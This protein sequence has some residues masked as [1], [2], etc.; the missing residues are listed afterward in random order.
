VLPAAAGALLEQ[1]EKLLD[2]GLHPLRIADG[3]EQA[4]KARA[5]AL[6][7]TNTTHQAL[8]SAIYDDEPVVGCL[9]CRIFCFA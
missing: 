8:P 5:P 4:C 1:A 2:M 7:R 6:S 9:D 3:Y